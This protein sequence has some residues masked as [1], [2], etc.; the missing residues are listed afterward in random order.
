MLE[1]AA[2]FAVYLLLKTELY[3]AEDCVVCNTTC[4][5]DCCV[6]TAY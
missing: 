6:A 2:I 3:V 1:S 5:G 4:V